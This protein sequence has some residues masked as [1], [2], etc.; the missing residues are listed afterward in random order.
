MRNILSRVIVAVFSVSFVVDA[1][2]IPKTPVSFK[3]H[4]FSHQINR[5]TDLKSSSNAAT[6]CFENFSQFS[7][8]GAS[9][10]K[11]SS[12]LQQDQLHSDTDTTT[13]E[14][15]VLATGFSNKLD[16]QAALKDALRAAREGIPPNTKNVDLAMVMVSSLYDGSSSS[17]PI[18]IVVPFLLQEAVEKYKTEILNLVGCTSGGLISSALNWDAPRQASAPLDEKEG[19][20]DTEAHDDDDDFE[21]KKQQVKATIPIESEGTPGVSI[22]LCVLPDV[23]ISVRI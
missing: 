2:R 4:I 1:F 17:S 9:S 15:Q 6:D 18:S 22:T 21:L 3:R 20:E 19:R 5:R 7:G 8:T 10:S 14:P 13:P 12:Q 23:E 16:L 11:E